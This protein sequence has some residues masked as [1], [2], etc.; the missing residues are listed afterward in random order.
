V[1]EREACLV[2]VYDTLLWVDFEQHR[3]ELPALA[4]LSTEAW[5][6]SMRR[7]GRDTG[8]GRLTTAEGYEQ[9]L[10]SNSGQAPPELVKALVE[11]D[12][13]LLLDRARLYDDSLPF[14]RELRARGIKI[15]IVSNCGPHTRDLLESNGVAELADALV[16]SCEFGAFKPDAGIYRDA[17]AQVGV[18]AQ[19]AVF[20]D[21]Q[22]LFCAGAAGL[23]ITAV[24]IVR[25]EQ[26]DKVPAPGTTV[27]R[28]LAEVLTLF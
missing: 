28:S 20:V 18:A 13:E 17:L 15:A 2:D 7:I 14:L 25:G 19:A 6:T 5:I 23:G 4:G 11:K 8:T 1:T 16:L 27:V 26:G 21:D 3:G 12:R 10:R 22:P 9:L 24:Q